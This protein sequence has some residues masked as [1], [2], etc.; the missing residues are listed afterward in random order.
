MFDLSGVTPDTFTNQVYMKL[1]NY[2]A[3]TLYNQAKALGVVGNLRKSDY[4][5]VA[6]QYARAI[7]E[8]F[9]TTENLPIIPYKSFKGTELVIHSGS[10]TWWMRNRVG[11]GKG[12]APKDA[13]VDL[14]VYNEFVTGFYWDKH[15]NMIMQYTDDM[16]EYALYTHTRVKWGDIWA[17]T[18]P[19]KHIGWIKRRQFFINV[20]AYDDL[21]QW[22]KDDIK[23]I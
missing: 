6:F 8:V 12:S 21:D 15:D 2:I 11:A 10:T 22:L 13:D 20:D 5:K 7:R 19:N 18:L 17:F 9:I 14:R 3:S 4:A 23:I 1:G 16:L